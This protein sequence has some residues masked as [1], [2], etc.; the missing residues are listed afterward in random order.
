MQLERRERTDKWLFL[1]AVG[2]F[3]LVVLYILKKRLGPM[4]GFFWSFVPLPGQAVQY[5]PCRDPSVVRLPHRDDMYRT[6][7][8]PAV[9]ARRQFCTC[10]P[11]IS[12]E[13][14]TMYH[15]EA[16]TSTMFKWLCDIEG[17]ASVWRIFLFLRVPH[18]LFASPSDPSFQDSTFK[19]SVALTIY[20]IIKKSKGRG[21]LRRKYNQL[22]TSSLAAM[23]CRL[24]ACGRKF[25]YKGTVTL[26]HPGSSGQIQ[27]CV[28]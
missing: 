17:A 21:R 20:I 11:F 10:Q 16:T 23:S 2:F 4:F 18:A 6:C 5:T 13:T 1:V 14:T 8:R 26:R 9:R 3:C 27:G 15:P 7:E 19:E 25:E 12:V 28:L 24:L 22:F